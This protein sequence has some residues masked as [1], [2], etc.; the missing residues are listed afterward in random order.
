MHSKICRREGDRYDIA[1]LVRKQEIEVLH[2]ATL[3]DIHD[4]T[5]LRNLDSWLMGYQPDATALLEQTSLP[6]N[7]FQLLV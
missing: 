1:L 5:A 6:L 4:I 3:H 7:Y 2:N